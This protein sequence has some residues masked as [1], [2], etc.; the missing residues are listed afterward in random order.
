MRFRLVAFLS[1][2][3]MLTSGCVGTQVG[4]TLFGT[5]SN[6][7][8]S[9]IQLSFPTAPSRKTGAGV[10]LLDLTVN[11]YDKWGHLITVPYS[12]NI[13]LSSTGSACEVGFAFFQ[14]AGSSTPPPLFASLAFNAPQPV[15]IAFDPNCPPNPVTITAS[16][17]GALNATLTF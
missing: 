10:Q 1:L 12:T 13:T 7:V 6:N 8:I 3:A 15:A 5:P 14:T 16:A 4:R 2:A 9:S 11:A 17:N